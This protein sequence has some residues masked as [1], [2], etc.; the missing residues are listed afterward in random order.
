MKRGAQGDPLGERDYKPTPRGERKVPHVPTTCTTEE[1]ATCT[2]TSAT[3][4]CPSRDYPPPSPSIHLHP[5]PPG[6]SSFFSA[7]AGGCPPIYCTTV[8][9]RR[10]LTGGPGRRVEGRRETSGCFF[11][12][13][14]GAGSSPWGLQLSLSCISEYLAIPKPSPEPL[15]VNLLPASTLG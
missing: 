2:P 13:M 12:D 4:R 3:N 7:Q 9:P 14:A 10:W 11:P 6:H 5:A 15:L 1:T 8:S